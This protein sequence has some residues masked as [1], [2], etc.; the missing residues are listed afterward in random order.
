MDLGALNGLA[1]VGVGINLAFGIVRQFR[2]SLRDNFTRNANDISSRMS[3]ALAEVGAA[4]QQDKLQ[5]SRQAKIS[6]EQFEAFSV[7]LSAVF[8]VLA[9][10]AGTLLIGFMYFA[11]DHGEAKCGLLAKNTVTF[12]A[13]A[14]VI[15]WAAIL[16][17]VYHR[18]YK[19]ILSLADHD[20][21]ALDI[22]NALKLPIQPTDPGTGS[23]PPKPGN[24]F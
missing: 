21:H 15:I 11:A 5:S 10:V 8:T 22:I 16:G 6:A 13:V 1:E 19:K 3:T 4:G 18:V 23:E 14:P 24:G 9:L 12:L 20:G 2:E 7:K 17:V